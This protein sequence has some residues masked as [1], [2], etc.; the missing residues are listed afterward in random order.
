[1]SLIVRLSNPDNARI[2]KELDY[3]INSEKPHNFVFL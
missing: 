2:I 1:M 3:A